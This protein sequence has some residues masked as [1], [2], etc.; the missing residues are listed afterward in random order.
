MKKY[1]VAGI[2]NG[3]FCGLTGISLWLTVMMGIAI[4]LLM[5]YIAEY[6]KLKG[7]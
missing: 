1:V 3:I 5:F 2:I 7:E 4:Y 6:K